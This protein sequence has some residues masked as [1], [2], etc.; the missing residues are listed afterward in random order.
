MNHTRQDITD[1]IA[2]LNKFCYTGPAYPRRPVRPDFRGETASRVRA[3]ADALEKYESD[4]AAYNKAQNDFTVAVNNARDAIREAA[5]LQYV[6]IYASPAA[7]R[8]VWDY[9]G[10]HNDNLHDLYEDFCT[11]MAMIQKFSEANA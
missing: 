6:G 3:Y 4:I 5:I 8:V 2:G 11:H 10:D 7:V 1:M 9:A